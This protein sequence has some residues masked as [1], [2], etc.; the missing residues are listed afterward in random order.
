[1][2]HR[3]RYFWLWIFMIN[4]MTF[5]CDRDQQFE[6]PDLSVP[7]LEIEG[8]IIDIDAL[9]RLW[10]QELDQNGNQILTFEDSIGLYTSG[11]VISS[12]EG[13][14]FF[15]ELII[16]NAPSSPTR[17]VKVLLDVNPL[18]TVFELGRKVYIKLDGM[19]VGLNN[20][21]LSLGVKNGNSIDKL[22][23]SQLL[24]VIAR[25]PEV[26]EIQPMEISISDITF[27]QTNLFVALKDVQFVRNEVLGDSRKT[28]AAEPTDQFDGERLLEDCET[29]SKV[30]LSTSSFADFKAVLL[31]VGRGNLDALLTMDFF[32]ESFNLVVNDP[33]SIRFERDDRCDPD[34]YI[35]DQ[36]SGGGPELFAENFEQSNS[37]EEYIALGW[38]I[39][40]EGDGSTLFEIGN[41]DNNNY[42]QIS[43]FNSGE[44]AI[45]SW[46]VTP[47]VEMDQTVGEELHFDVQASFDN[48]ATLSVLFSTNYSGDI[49]AANWI[50]LDAIIPSGPD[51]GFGDFEAVGPINIACMEGVVHFAFR[52]EGNDPEATT[53]YH[54]D[55]IKITGN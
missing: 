50:L 31:P 51:D 53:R 43:G 24:D 38:N 23:E 6:T 7:E 46:L 36:P 9:Y 42:A 33:S 12:D 49:A 54:I 30:V 37:I 17:G 20:G 44:A 41:F 18:Y 34:F 3:N 32:G 15:E 4:C 26:V 2:K 27:E 55:N 40:N 1:M 21:V 39:L 19:T 8:E 48:G 47:A 16:Q 35:C 28:F 10:Q 45:R 5:S 25:D 22:A 14:N 13:G 11:Y 52:Y 29:A